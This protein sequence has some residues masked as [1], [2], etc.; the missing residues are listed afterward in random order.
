[1]LSLVI[2]PN[3]SL[4][5]IAEPVSEVNDDIRRLIDEMYELMVDARGIGLAGPMVGVSKRIIIV[6]LQDDEHDRVTLINPVLKQAG[7]E[8]QTHEEASLCYPGIA[9]NI[10]RPNDITVEYQDTDGK[11]QTLNA[12]GWFA[13]VILHEMEY[14]DGKSF[15]DGLS[16]MKRDRLMK[17]MDKFKKA[18]DRAGTSTHQHGPNCGPGCDEET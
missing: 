12:S 6:D 18:H 10:T 1:M 17:R 5:K 4:K 15:I 9:A 7:S 2:A 16:K 13:Q 8:Q 11:A 3:P 14:L